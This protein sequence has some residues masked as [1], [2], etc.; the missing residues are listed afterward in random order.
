MVIF[1]TAESTLVSLM[2]Y[3]KQLTY[4]FFFC[5]FWDLCGIIFVL[6]EQESIWGGRKDLLKWTPTCKCSRMSCNIR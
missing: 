6:Q 2:L 5:P 4:T 1:D 3:L